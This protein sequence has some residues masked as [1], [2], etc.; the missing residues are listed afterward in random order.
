MKA[1]RDDSCELKSG[2]Y[3][4]EDL[5]N[6]CVTDRY[7]IEMDVKATAK[8]Y[9]LT[10]QSFRTKYGATQIEDMFRKSPRLIIRR[11]K[12]SDH[13]ICVWDDASFTIYPYR[14]GVPYVF[15]LV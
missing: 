8:S 12:P 14:V 7:I 5:D 3:R 9:I 6:P 1:S 11:N 2:R 4:S 10:L 15:N 13:A